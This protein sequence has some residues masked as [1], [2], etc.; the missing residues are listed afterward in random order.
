MHRNRDSS[1]L[2]WKPHFT[3][4]SV[5]AAALDG[6]SYEISVGTLSEVMPLPPGHVLMISMSSG[7]D[8]YTAA[9][10]HPGQ[11]EMQL[12]RDAE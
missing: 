9:T 7:V 3:V 5:P 10:L 11:H 1:G 4:G 8:V 2:N 6:R 12:A